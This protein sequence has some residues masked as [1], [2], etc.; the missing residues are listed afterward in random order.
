MKYKRINSKNMLACGWD[1]NW[2]KCKRYEWKRNIVTY[3][4]WA[5]GFDRAGIKRWGHEPTPTRC[6]LTIIH[7]EGGN[8]WAWDSRNVQH[9]FFFFP[10]CTQLLNAYR[11]AYMLQSPPPT[12]MQRWRFNLMHTVVRKTQGLHILNRHI[13]FK[14]A[15]LSKW[16]FADSRKDLESSL[17]STKF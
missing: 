12:W 8:G 17:C 9:A 5:E 14:H 11:R 4:S 10:S 6:M 13:R 16:Q 1:N 15:T 3:N 7:K 2:W